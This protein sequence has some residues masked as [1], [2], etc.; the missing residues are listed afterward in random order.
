M[1][2]QRGAAAIGNDDGFSTGALYGACAG[3]AG[4]LGAYFLLKKYK[5][6]KS[7]DDFERA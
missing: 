1:P 4:V 7:Y 3:I 5:N 2:H 6:T